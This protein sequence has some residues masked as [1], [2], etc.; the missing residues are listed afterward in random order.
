MAYLKIIILVL[1]AIALIIG[2]GGYYT[3]S[4]FHAPGPHDLARIVLIPEGASV[5]QAARVLEGEGVLRS[6]ELFKWGTRLLG[7]DR[8]IRAGEY[9]VPARASMAGILKI[10]RSGNVVQHPFTVPEGLSSPQ[11]VALLMADDTLTGEIGAIPS[12]GT[13]LPET[14]LHVR[15]TARADIIQ[16]MSTAFRK[17]L[18][19]LW[20][21]RDIDRAP[22]T[23]GE[24]VTLASIVEKETAVPE[25]RPRVAAVF[26]NRLEKGMRLQSDPTVVYAVTGGFPIGRRITR[27][28]LRMDSPYN[29]YKN[30]GLPPGPIAN[31]GVQSL[32]AVLNPI[33][34]DEYYFVADGTGG[35]VFSRT[36]E[37]HNRNVAKWRKIRRQ[38]DAEDTA[39]S[40]GGQAG[41]KPVE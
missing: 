38:M 3:Y 13:L 12:E 32:K 21:G 10:L 1:M 11:V 27:D 8:H 26:L 31:P 4:R 20:V 37:E 2:G 7:A 40:L 9:E 16:R 5:G 19:E 39:P 23:P 18:D 41:D 22:A 14:Y 30:H 36:L 24:A 33:E 29:T 28:D 34:T 6:S 25:E 17:A 35:H 15:G